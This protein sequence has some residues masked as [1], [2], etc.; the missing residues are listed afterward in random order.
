MPENQGLRDFYEYLLTTQRIPK[1]K[2][3]ISKIPFDEF[4]A[5]IELTCQNIGL[6]A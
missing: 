4:S 3:G 2:F 1:S 6:Y 5:F